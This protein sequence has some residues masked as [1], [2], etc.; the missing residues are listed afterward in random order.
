MKARFVG[1]DIGI[2]L[3]MTLYMSPGNKAIV[4]K[5]EHGPLHI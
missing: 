2:I 4:L 1:S 3:Y 5:F